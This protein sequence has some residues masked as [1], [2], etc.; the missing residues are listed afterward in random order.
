MAL[1]DRQTE[2]IVAAILTVGRL[3]KT[4]NLKSADTYV[5]HYRETLSG[6]RKV[7]PEPEDPFA[8]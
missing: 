7:T 1:D 4:E 8:A 2:R 5:E 6:L 3:A